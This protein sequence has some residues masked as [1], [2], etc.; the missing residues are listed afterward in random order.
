MLTSLAEIQSL[1]IQNLV[2]RNGTVSVQ[3]LS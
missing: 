1:G 2:Y 3:I